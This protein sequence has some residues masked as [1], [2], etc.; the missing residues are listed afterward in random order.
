MKNVLKKIFVYSLLSMFFIGFA[1]TLLTSQKGRGY[2][3]YIKRVKGYI[4]VEGSLYDFEK[5][6]EKQEPFKQILKDIKDKQ[7]FMFGDYHRSYQINLLATRMFIFL[8]KN[9]NYDDLLINID[10]EYQK[11]Y[12]RWLETGE[13]LGNFVPYFTKPGEKLIRDYYKSLPKNRKF[14]IYCIKNAAQ[15]EGETFT[16]LKT[17]MQK[18]GNDESFR[19]VVNSNRIKTFIRKLFDKNPDKKYFIYIPW[20]DTTKFSDMSFFNYEFETVGTYLNERNEHT[21]GEVISTVCAIRSGIVS[22]GDELVSVVP[23]DDFLNLPFLIESVIGFDENTYLLPLTKG[24]GKGYVLEQV[25]NYPRG[26][27]Q[28]DTIAPPNQIAL[29]ETR[30]NKINKRWDYLF[31][32]HMISPWKR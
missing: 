15:D 1:C 19:V 18:G 31:Y 17:F 14:K 28:L 20:R 30:Y 7:I 4:G 24:H 23:N 16:S 25:E 9:A 22:F 21:K 6:L 27:W 10:A 11:E 8:H 32:F 26:G 3:G 29:V 13:K 2:S 5:D 12:D